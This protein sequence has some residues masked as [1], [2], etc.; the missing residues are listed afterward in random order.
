MLLEHHPFSLP[1]LRIFRCPGGFQ[2]TTAAVNRSSLNH[3]QAKA[4]DAHDLSTPHSPAT[5]C[6]PA[7]SSNEYRETTNGET[8]S[9]KHSSSP[10]I[11]WS[12][13]FR[14]KGRHLEA[15]LADRANLHL[16][17]NFPLADPSASFSILQDARLPRR[18]N[19]SPRHWTW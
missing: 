1:T 3:W 12:R 17:I 13:A 10:Y 11:R 18:V 19:D 4:F 7:S 5:C 16:L 8:T 14:H 6:V 15:V 9:D 2:S